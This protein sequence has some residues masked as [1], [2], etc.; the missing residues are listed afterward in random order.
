MNS[1]ETENR[2]IA[3][4]DC[5]GLESIFDVN[6]ELK[7]R[8]DWKKQQIF[9]VLNEVSSGAYQTTIPLQLLLLRA[10]ANMQRSYEIYEFNTTMSMEDVQDIF[11]NS[12]QIIVDWIRENGNK[13]YSDYVGAK[14]KVIV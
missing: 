11:N 10:K 3:V 7:A 4:W 14:Q 13:I 2:F 5:D 6:E 8:E 9:D 12:P 1:Y